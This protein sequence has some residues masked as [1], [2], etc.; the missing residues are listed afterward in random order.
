MG[1]SLAQYKWFIL[2]NASIR[3]PF[4]P[5]WSKECSSDAYLDK[6]M[7][8]VKVRPTH[9]SENPSSPHAYMAGF[10]SSE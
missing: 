9:F 1:K 8:K 7:G 2:M 4:V 5:Y 6:V 3:D 10:S